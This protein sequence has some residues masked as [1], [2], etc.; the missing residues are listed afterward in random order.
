MAQNFI[1]LTNNMEYVTHL[2]KNDPKIATTSIHGLKYYDPVKYYDFHVYY[3]H[4]IESS[5]R[6]SDALRE[7]LL[8]DFPE[9]TAN[10]SII[11]KKLPDGNTIGPH[12]TQFWEA[13]VVRPEVFVRLLSWFQL[14]HGSLSV[15]IHPNTGDGLLDHTHRALWLGDRLPV[16][17]DIFPKGQ[18]GIAEF[19][20]KGGKSIAPE[21]FD[22]HVSQPND[23]SWMENCSTLDE[24]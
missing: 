3:I 13:D 19:G 23:Q 21:D 16:V 14:F 20:V 24:A 6:E 12:I 7:K 4:R 15:L 10:G 18:T 9:E 2:P 17:T 5:K 11:V 22:D 8:A 1:Q